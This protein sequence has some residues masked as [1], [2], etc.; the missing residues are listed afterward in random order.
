MPDWS[1]IL[2]IGSDRPA[3]PIAA[4]SSSPP[5][6]VMLALQP[7]WWLAPIATT[8]IGLGFYMF[9][10]TLAD[11]SH[12]DDAGGTRH[13]RRFL[14]VGALPRADRGVAIGALVIDRAGAKPLFLGTA[15]AFPL[16]AIWFAYELRR[17]PRTELS[18]PSFEARAKARSSDEVADSAVTP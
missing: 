4:D 11:Q 9:H 2:C 6:I 3:L 5:P 7:V 17:R 18:W 10:N 12:A 13:R 14:H 15:I 16:L 1:G 8:A